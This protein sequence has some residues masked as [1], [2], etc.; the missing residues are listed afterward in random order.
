MK[1]VNPEKVANLLK[2]YIDECDGDALA[3]IFEHL[4]SGVKA[5]W[6]EDENDGNIEYELE[7]DIADPFGEDV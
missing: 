4:F 3:A 6:A 7:A 1:K 5:T 2:V